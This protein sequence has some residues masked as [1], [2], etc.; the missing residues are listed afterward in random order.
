MWDTCWGRETGSGRSCVCGGGLSHISWFLPVWSP[1]RETA[2]AAGFGEGSPGRGEVP[3]VPDQ[4]CRPLGIA[5][6]ST[7]DRNFLPPTLTGLWLSGSSSFETRMGLVQG[8]PESHCLDSERGSGVGVGGGV[9]GGGALRRE[10]AECLTGNPGILAELS[11]GLPRAG[12]WEQVSR[13]PGGWEEPAPALLDAYDFCH[14]LWIQCASGEAVPFISRSNPTCCLVSALRFFPCEC[15][16]GTAP[17]TSVIGRA[18][19]FPT[20]AG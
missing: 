3:C 11:R 5:S 18:S 9:A 8:Y 15:G 19:Q 2:A 7:E 12:L 16:G 13:S 6:I 1:D 10:Q 4:G 14:P 17:L 20:D